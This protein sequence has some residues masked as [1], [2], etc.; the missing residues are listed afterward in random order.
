MRLSVIAGVLFYQLLAAGIADQ[1]VYDEL[2]FASD[3]EPF[4]TLEKCFSFTH[5][6]S[7]GYD[8]F[9]TTPIECI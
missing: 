2:L 5:G 8:W 6:A 4:N 9:I 7:Y 1:I 3:E